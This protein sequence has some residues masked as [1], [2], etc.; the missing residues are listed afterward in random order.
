MKIALLIISCI[1]VLCLSSA[2]PYRSPE[3]KFVVVTPEKTG[4]HLLTKAIE[5]LVNKKVRNCWSQTI[6]KKDLLKELQEAKKS[7]CF[8]HIHALPTQEIIDTLKENS[9]RVIFLMRDPRDVVISFYYY[10]ESGW[11]YG[12]FC[13]RNCFYSEFSQDGKRQEII[14]GDVFGVSIPT[15][16][17]GGRIPWMH[18]G[19]NFV[20]TAR[21]ENLVGATGGG[22]DELQKNEIVN[23]A[24]HIGVT[25]DHNLLSQVTT[26]LFGGENER[27]FRKGKIGSWKDE[28][29]LKDKESF[30]KVF[31]KQLIDLGYEQ[32]NDW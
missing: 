20:Y 6:S 19:S 1:G 2:V 8:F 21:F 32:N 5:R 11:T 4:T 26:N 29:N 3:P 15:D 17:I 13:P 28:F 16:I 24:N 30:K 22:S 27:T 9:Y 23:I 25:L 7:N 14:S 18:Q 12:P 10:V 31:G